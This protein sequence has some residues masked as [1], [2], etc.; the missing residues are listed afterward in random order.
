[1]TYPTACLDLACSCHTGASAPN[2]SSAYADLLPTQQELDALGQ[3]I[4]EIR[5]EEIGELPGGD[6]DGDAALSSLEDT[7][8]L[9]DLAYASEAARQAEDAVPPRRTSE[10][11]FSR[12][13]DRIAAGSYTLA[14]YY[15]EPE[16]SHGCGPLDEFGRCSAR[17]HSGSCFETVRGEPAVAGGE[18]SDAWNRTLL[19]NPTSADVTLARED[20]ASW[21]DLMDSSPAD[22]GTYQ[23]MRAVLGIGGRQ[24]LP[25]PPERSH[26]ARELGLY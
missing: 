6:W 13:L 10:E 19:S 2:G 22:T 17:Y 24:D 12:A 23:H 9:V 11:R 14:N 1:M 4:E 15:R 16:P 25:A 5:A 7:G 21:E 18:G 20:L 3:I 26:L 8:Q